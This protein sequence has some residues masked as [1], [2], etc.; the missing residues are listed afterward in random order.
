MERQ[1]QKPGVPP[2]VW[3]LIVLLALIL[4]FVI[5]WAVAAQAPQPEVITPP[6]EETQEPLVQPPEQPVAIERERPVNIYIERERPPQQGPRVVIV[7]REEQPP[8]ARERFR[9][10]DLP[11]RFRY[12]GE[13]W[14]PSDEALI[15]DQVNLRDTGASVDGNVIYAD[16]FAERPYDE[17]Y[18]ETEPGSDIYIKYEKTS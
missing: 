10:I 8:Q 5:W 9:R 15:G 1:E 2:W 16:Q 4:V 3:V 17:L 18:L 6:D 11:S 14:E 12:Q 13:V 7:P